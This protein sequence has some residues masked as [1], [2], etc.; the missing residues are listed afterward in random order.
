LPRARDKNAL[1]SFII[2]LY[3]FFNASLNIIHKTTKQKKR[4]ISN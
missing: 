3:D 2:L 4:L 1:K